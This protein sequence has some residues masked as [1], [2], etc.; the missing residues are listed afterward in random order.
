M[1]AGMS[2]RSLPQGAICYHEYGSALFRAA[3]LQQND[4]ETEERLADASGKAD[5][6]AQK[7]TE[8]NVNSKPAAKGAN[9]VKQPT[10]ESVDTKPAAKETNDDNNDQKTPSNGK[11]GDNNDDEDGRGGDDDEDDIQLALKMIET[12]CGSS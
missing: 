4:K 2:V 3:R 7:R 6:A 9:D 1:M 12:A 5:Q 11:E 8:E 10:E